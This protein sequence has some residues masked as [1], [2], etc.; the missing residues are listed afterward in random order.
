MLTTIGNG[1][2]L[3][4]TTTLTDIPGISINLAAGGWY[5]VKGW[6]QF[7]TSSTTTT[8]GFSLGGT[9]GEVA[10]TVYTLTIRNNTSDSANLQLSTVIPGFANPSGVL[11]TATTYGAAIDGLVVVGTAGTLTMQAKHGAAPAFTIPTNGAAMLVQ[12][13][14]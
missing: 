14:A 8:A 4:S 6:I 2:P 1:G 10:P 3:T 12:Q 9:A 7:T 5:L 11:A 13:I